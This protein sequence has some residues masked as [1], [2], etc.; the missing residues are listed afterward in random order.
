MIERVTTVGLAV[1]YDGPALAAGSME[2]SDLAPALLGIAEACQRSNFMLNGNGLGLS[3]KVNAD[4]QSGCFHV[5]LLLT[6]AA[7]TL[8]PLMAQAPQTLKTAKEIAEALFAGEFSVAG[9]I[10]RLRGHDPKTIDTKA[11]PGQNISLS[12][13]GNNNTTT[14]IMPKANWDLA[15][16]PAVRKSLKKAV[17]PL[18][19]PGVE[20][21]EIG[22]PGSQLILSK[23][24]AEYFT[25]I[26]REQVTETE[27]DDQL[28]I[29]AFDFNRDKSRFTDGEAEFSA[30]IADE[31]FWSDVDNRKYRPGKGDQLQVTLLVRKTR[32]LRLRTEYIIKIVLR[33]IQPPEQGIL[34]LDFDD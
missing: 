30:I 24:D 15:N 12:I 5:D 3:V 21:L 34:P 31:S 18:F 29:V 9:V 1:I 16:D 13:Q 7:T 6:Q 28:E 32:G 26:A 4:I 2:V 19:R 20:T 25:E 10:R 27:R 8:A 33:I 11:E 17:T 23:S 14:I 22:E